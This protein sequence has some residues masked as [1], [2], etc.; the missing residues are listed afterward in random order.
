M[1]DSPENLD[2]VN[3]DYLNTVGS[4]VHRALRDFLSG[5]ILPKNDAPLSDQLSDRAFDILLDEHNGKKPDNFRVSVFHSVAAGV[6]ATMRQTLEDLSCKENEQTPEIKENP[7]KEVHPA[8]NEIPDN[9]PKRATHA[10]ELNSGEFVF[11]ELSDSGRFTV[12]RGSPITSF[13]RSMQPGQEKTYEDM[14]TNPNQLFFENSAGIKTLKEDIVFSSPALASAII[15]GISGKSEHWIDR[16]GNSLSR[17][18]GR[19]PASSFDK[20]KLSGA[21]YGWRPAR[22]QGGVQTVK[23]GSVVM[24]CYPDRDKPHIRILKIVSDEEDHEHT[25]SVITRVGPSKPI[26]EAIM[27]AEELE[28]V[29][30]KSSQASEKPENVLIIKI[31]ESV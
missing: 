24:V 30:F 19:G 21:V 7:V 23:Q 6:V 9:W 15:T 5:E 20:T 25:D 4:C 12:F 10:M 11:G 1:N 14:L 13:P 3:A 8:S 27:G 26:A 16:D 29:S 18:R 2:Y 28:I 17:G 22:H 31:L